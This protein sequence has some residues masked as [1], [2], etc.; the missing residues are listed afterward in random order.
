[1]N[2]LMSLQT[3]SYYYHMNSSD[4]VFDYVSP[5]EVWQNSNIIRGYFLTVQRR[6]HTECGCVRGMLITLFHPHS[7]V[8][9]EFPI[10]KPA[11]EYLCLQGLPGFRQVVIH[12]YRR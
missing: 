6:A 9:G 11:F 12:S 7:V 5:R 8:F 3:A 10:K 4:F 1:M 2:G